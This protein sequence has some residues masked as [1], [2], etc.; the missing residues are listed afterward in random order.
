MAVGPKQ[1][2]N[3]MGSTLV[4]LWARRER[5]TCDYAELYRL[6]AKNSALRSGTPPRLG[7]HNAIVS[8]GVRR[9]GLRSLRPLA[10][11]PLDDIGRAL[12]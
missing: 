2:D 1:L 11:D 7:V 5:T 4:Q 3:G 8:A 9:I 6:T 12:E 10:N